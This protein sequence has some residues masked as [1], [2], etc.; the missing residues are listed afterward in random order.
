M[1]MELHRFARVEQCIEYGRLPEPLV[2]D[3][4]TEMF[5]V[6]CLVRLKQRPSI[7]IGSVVTV[8]TTLRALSL[9]P[10]G[11]IYLKWRYFKLAEKYRRR[12][13]LRWMSEPM[14]IWLL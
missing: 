9:V 2:Q 7:I 13:C 12:F 6:D 3:E 4:E 8:F 5:R 11:L 14:S 1:Q 10:T